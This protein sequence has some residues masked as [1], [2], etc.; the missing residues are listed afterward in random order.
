MEIKAFLKGLGIMLL[1]QF[2]LNY[3]IGW[4]YPPA[5]DHLGFTMTAMAALGFF[6]V[7]I[8][9]AARVAAASSLSRLF[10]Q[11]VMIAVFVKMLLCLALIIG[12]KKMFNPPDH[13]FIWTFLIIYVTSTIYEVIFMEKTGRPKKKQLIP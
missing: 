1:I 10:I 2:G 5:G 11:L 12:Y 13:S 4:I 9:G 8:F 3:L 6:C 7:M